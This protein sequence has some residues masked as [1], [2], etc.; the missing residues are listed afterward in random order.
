MLNLRQGQT[1]SDEINHI[2]GSDDNESLSEA[3]QYSL[4]AEFYKN[5][6]EEELHNLDN[7][8]DKE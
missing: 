2:A 5:M 6:R 8:L 4:Y 7:Y 1:L 3:Q